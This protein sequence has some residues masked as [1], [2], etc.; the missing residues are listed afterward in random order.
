MRNAVLVVL[1]LVAACHPPTLRERAV[2]LGGKIS[3]LGHATVRIVAPVVPPIDAQAVANVA[4]SAAVAQL[5]VPQPQPIEVHHSVVRTATAEPA[6]APVMTVQRVDAAPRTFF[7]MRYTKTGGGEA[8]QRFDTI[9]ACNSACT[10][11]SQQRGMRG[12]PNASCSC[13]EDAPGC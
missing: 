1:A 6:A 13:L 2:Q 3:A 8:C 5:P 9:D 11:L 7:G 12:E 4:V 10:S